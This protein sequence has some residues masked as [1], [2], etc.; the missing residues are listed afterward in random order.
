M[1]E[2]RSPE[3]EIE[4][5]VSDVER[6]LDRIFETDNRA[7]AEVDQ[8]R[9]ALAALPEETERLREEMRR[10]RRQKVEQD[11]DAWEARCRADAEEEC[12]RLTAESEAIAAR[13]SD[14]FAEKRADWLEEIVSAVTD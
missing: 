5:K 13:L 4:G 8:A 12:R 11:L 3:R 7:R 9:Q 2:K 14:A 1:D 10:Q 6:L